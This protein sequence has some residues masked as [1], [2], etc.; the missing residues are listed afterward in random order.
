MR[1]RG[2]G[3]TA[4]KPASMKGDGTL[5]IKTFVWYV[6]VFVDLRHRRRIPAGAGGEFQNL[7][8]QNIDVAAAVQAQAFTTPGIDGRTTNRSDGSHVS[9]GAGAEFQDI[10][11]IVRGAGIDSRRDVG[12]SRV[13]LQACKLEYSIVSPK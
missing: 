7:V 8:I 2:A 6:E 12:S 11:L 13:D 10:L 9:G 4:Q 3:G 5:N 1:S